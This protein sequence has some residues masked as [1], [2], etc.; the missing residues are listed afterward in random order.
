MNIIRRALDLDAAIDKRLRELASEQ[1]KDVS[2]ILAEAV[3][4]LD[5]IVDIGAPDIEE[6]R[7]RLHGFKKNAPG[8]PAASGQSVG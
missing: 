6:D 7:R 5:S 4:L 8:G 3:A 2:V 1:G